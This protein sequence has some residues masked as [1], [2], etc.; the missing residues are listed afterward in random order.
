MSFE[1]CFRKQLRHASGSAQA[2]PC[3]LWLRKELDV[4]NFY[5]F[6]LAWSWSFARFPKNMWTYE[7][8]FWFDI[9]TGIESPD[10]SEFTQSFRMTKTKAVHA[11]S[12]ATLQSL[13]RSATR[14][15]HVRQGV[16]L[17][18]GQRSKGKSCNMLPLGFVAFSHQ[19]S[20]WYPKLGKVPWKSVKPNQ[21]PTW[22][23]VISRY[24]HL[25]GMKSPWLGIHIGPAP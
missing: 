2:W 19:K 18:D 3:L 20:R 9:S 4:E 17:S 7:R 23:L 5:I 6:C 16:S 13:V 14:M 21:L 24:P 1:R 25:A 11:I 10:Y 15:G 8:R 22:L 12:Y